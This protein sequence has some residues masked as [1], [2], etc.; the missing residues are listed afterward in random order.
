MDWVPWTGPEGREESVYRRERKGPIE[1]TENFFVKI[2]FLKVYMCSRLS[3]LPGCTWLTVE[4]VHNLVNIKIK[5]LWDCRR[6]GCVCVS[7][8]VTE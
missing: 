8:C 2:I 7:V 4:V 6:G 1:T 5:L 3:G